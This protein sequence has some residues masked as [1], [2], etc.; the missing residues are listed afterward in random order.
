MQIAEGLDRPHPSRRP[1]AVQIHAGRAS[2]GQH[3]ALLDGAALPR[4]RRQL[5]LGAAGRHRGARP[6][7]PRPPHG[8]RGRRHHRGQARRRGDDRLGRSAQGDEPL[9]LRVADRARHAGQ[10]G[11]PALR[12]RRRADLPARE[13]SLSAWRRN[14]ASTRQK[15]EFMR[16][17]EILRRS[18]KRWSAAPRW[19]AAS[20]TFPTSRPTRNTIGRKPAGSATS[21][22]CS[23][24]RCCARAF[25]SA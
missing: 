20:S 1:A 5:A 3:A 25:R 10:L 7:R 18:A 19:S 12:G 6:G 21:A 16:G 2:Q 14:T 4:R 15:D 23:A 13:F 17:R 24:F 9:D 8:R 22:P 11:D